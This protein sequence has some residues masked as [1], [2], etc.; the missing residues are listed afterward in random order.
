YARKKGLEVMICEKMP[1]VGGTTATSGGFAWVPGTEQAKAAGAKDSIEQA[2]TFLQHELGSYYRADLVDAF[3]E[4]GPQAIAT[5][6]QDTEVALDYVPWP[7]YHAD[8]VGGVIAGRTLESRRF[9]GR[10]LGKDFELVRPPIKRLM[11]LGGMSVDKRKVDD[12]LNPFSSVKG[13]FRV[14]ATFA[15]YAADR[16][17]YSRGTDIGAGNALIAR[18]LYSLRQL[19]AT[20]WV[21]APLVELVSEGGAVIGAV[22]RHEGKEKRI[23]A[24]RGVILA[25][26][27]FPHNA[28]MREELGPRHPHHHS[29]GWEANVGEGINAARRIGAVIDHDVVGPGLWQP[30]SILVH[31]DGTEETILYGYLDRGKPGVIAVDANGRRFVNESNSYHDI[32]EAMFRNGV[33]QGNRFYFICDRKFVWKRGLGLIRPFRPSLA[34]YVRDKY[35]TVADSIEE[36]A[37][38]IGVDP[39]GLVETV[40]RHNEYAKTGVDPEFR[41]GTNPFNTILLGDPK[42]KPNPNLGPI[43]QGPFVALRIYPSTL[44]TAIGLK[45]NADSQVLNAEGAPIE[46]LYACGQD[47][48]AVMRGFYP[49]GGIN[50]G[51]A[52]VFAYIA[53]RHLAAANGRPQRKPGEPDRALR[54]AA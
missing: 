27:G 34:P 11:L 41:R 49:A 7:D 44:G 4:A 32:G 36:L 14:V 9:D 42:V 6:Q 2:R 40:S 10:K 28:R 33:A 54:L 23:R 39:R 25:T 43:A 16:L 5:L 19:K 24:R 12:F 45:T 21:N 48:S 3:L 22:V 46:G 37:R 52:I 18:L 15:R 13:F 1:V 38:K 51:P 20:I 47:I 50:I 8:Q 26:G 17:Q 30:S 53:V 31:K 29:V 35:I